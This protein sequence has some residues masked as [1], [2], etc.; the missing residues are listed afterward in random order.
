MSPLDLFLI[1]VTALGSEGFYLLALPLVYWCVDCELGFELCCAFLSSAWANSALKALFRVPRPPLPMV[2]FPELHLGE[3]WSFPSG[4]A[5]GTASF[6]GYLA[7]KCRCQ[8]VLV[9]IAWAMVVLVSFSRVYLGVHWPA[10]VVGGALL[11]LGWAWSTARLIRLGPATRRLWLV[12]GIVLYSLFADPQAAAASGALQGIVVGH[13]LQTR[14]VKMDPR[15]T[16]RQ[17]LARYVLG[18]S[19]MACLFFGLKAIMPE[20]TAL[21][22]VRYALVALGVALGVPW[23]FVKGGLASGSGGTRP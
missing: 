6:W 20:T 13:L 23:L 15:G 4:H 12:A 8:P 10:D 17:R 9:G 3:G 22:F 14:W 7:F 1:G 11:G 5:Q 2:R 18:I 16:A 21:R 19:L